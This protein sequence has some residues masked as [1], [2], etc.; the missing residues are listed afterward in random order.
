MPKIF[1]DTQIF[2]NL[3]QTK[4]NLTKIFEDINKIRE[5]LIIPEQVKDEFIRNRDSKIRELKKQISDTKIEESLN[6]FGIFRKQPDFKECEESVKKLQQIRKQMI[7]YCDD[8]IANTEKD[9]VFRFFKKLYDDPKVQ[10]IERS[11]DI[12][13]KSH[14]RKLIGNP[15]ISAGKSSVGDEINWESIL[16]GVD[17]DLIIISGDGTYENNKT[18][19]YQEYQ[20][21]TGKK[22]LGIF[23][24]ISRAFPLINVKPSTELKKF[25]EEQRENELKK[26][27]AEIYSDFQ[28]EKPRWLHSILLFD[29]LIKNDRI[30]MKQIK[31]IPKFSNSEI[32]EFIKTYMEEKEKKGETDR[33]E[34]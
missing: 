4:V 15:P 25:E 33:K 8:I 32:T 30:R 29:N 20:Q 18:F 11:E 9:E 14:T 27:I 22:I 23:N 7:K 17:D 5:N 12:V 10:K 3:Y 1:I 19:L 2:L 21:K 28:N 6:S 34:K 31:H 24:E 16:D 26:Y 13:K